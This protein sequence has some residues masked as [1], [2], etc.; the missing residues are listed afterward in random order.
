MVFFVELSDK[1]NAILFKQ[2]K[3]LGHQTKE[4]L[5]NC[6]AKAGDSLVFSPAKKMVA[7][8][9]EQLPNGLTVFGGNL[10]QEAQHVFAQK[11][12]GY[13]NFLLD[14]RFVYSNALLTAE[15][16]LSMLIS[17]TEQS[18]FELSVLV[19]GYGRV[20]KAVASLINKLGIK[21]A[22]ATFDKH[23]Y[24]EACL[25][26]AHKHFGNNFA[27]QLGNYNVIINTIPHKIFDAKMQGKIAPNTLVLDV[28]SINCLD[29]S[30]KSNFV[31]MPAPSL[32]QKFS[33]ES[34]AKLMLQVIHNQIKNGG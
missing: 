18:I 4:L 16:V 26:N 22:I 8:Q 12:I 24:A 33:P 6:N 2:L 31:Y 15:G 23:E 3:A 10:S 30:S 25:L 32:P 5:N 9:A 7:S 21:Q 17:C 19:L 20:A 11:S 1:R 28:A 27:E 29:Q 14:E 34:A 13:I